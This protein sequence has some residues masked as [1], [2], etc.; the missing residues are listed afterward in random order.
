MER[1]YIYGFGS[2]FHSSMNYQDIDILLL[3]EKINFQSVSF[4]IK[5][6]QCLKFFIPLSDIL[7]MSLQEEIEINF[8]ANSK[9]IHIG[10]IRA[11]SMKQDLV[12][13]SNFILELKHGGLGIA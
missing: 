2:Y 6:K 3:H 10:I 7:I 13:L 11:N 8:L 4:A 1:L 9:A 5:A 12:Y